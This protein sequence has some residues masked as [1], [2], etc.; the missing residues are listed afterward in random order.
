VGYLAIAED[1]IARQTKRRQVVA[2]TSALTGRVTTAGAAHSEESELS[3]ISSDP[4]TSP[5]RTPITPLMQI[6]WARD[7]GLLRVFDPIAHEWHEVLAADCPTTWRDEAF[8]H[9]DEEREARR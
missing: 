1:V 3:A 2:A 6:R 7:R 8:R 5:V 4:P 9:R